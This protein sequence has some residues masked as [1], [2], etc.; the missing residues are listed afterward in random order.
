MAKTGTATYQWQI[1]QALG[2]SDD[3]IPKFAEAEY[4]LKYFPPHTKQDLRRMGLKV[5]NMHLF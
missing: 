4:W 3:E 2:L 1:M 5:C